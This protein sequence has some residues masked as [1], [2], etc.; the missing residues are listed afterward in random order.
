[1]ATATATRTA[2][3]AAAAAA[4]AA[5]RRRLSRAGLAGGPAVTL[6]PTS[7]RR[8]QNRLSSKVQASPFS[9]GV[10]GSSGSSGDALAHCEA[11]VKQYDFD[12]YIAGM[13]LP[14]HLRAA[15]YALRAFNVEIAIIKDQTRGN[16]ITSRVR[17]QWWRD[18]FDSVYGQKGLTHDYKTHPVGLVLS[19]SIQR[20]SLSRSWFDRTLEAR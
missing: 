9:S 8:Y 17:F 2:L 18:Y 13:L 20:F 12:N 5:G 1:M 14:Q 4:A 6:V 3:A 16:T 19:D 7:L 11:L 10:V 15:F